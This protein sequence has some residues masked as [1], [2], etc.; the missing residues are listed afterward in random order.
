[1]G[2]LRCGIQFKVCG[3][4]LAVYEYRFCMVSV[5][6]KVALELNLESYMTLR[7]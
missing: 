4:G 5:C 1:M 7:I 2:D 6:Q 3:V